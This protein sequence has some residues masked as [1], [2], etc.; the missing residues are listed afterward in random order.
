MPMLLE[1]FPMNEPKFCDRHF[2]V[3]KKKGTRQ[4]FLSVIACDGIM[5]IMPSQNEETLKSSPSGEYKVLTSIKCALLSPP[6][7]EESIPRKGETVHVD[8]D[9]MEM[10]RHVEEV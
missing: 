5:K 1:L 9:K 7:N 6:N 2:I 10:T 8:F 3:K 4:I